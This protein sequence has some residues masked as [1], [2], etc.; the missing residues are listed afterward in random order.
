[1]P[2][3]GQGAMDLSLGRIEYQVR[4]NGTASYTTVFKIDITDTQLGPFRCVY[5]FQVNVEDNIGGPT[6]VV[7]SATAN[8][9]DSSEFSGG[10]G[11][12]NFRCQV[13]PSAG[14][15]PSMYIYSRSGFV[16]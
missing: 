11:T 2:K 16:Q 8:G 12:S 7:A 15:G 3:E 14:R 1:M 5:T 9:R 6:A 10:P 4:V 13:A